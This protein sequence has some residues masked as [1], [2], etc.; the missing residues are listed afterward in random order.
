MHATVVPGIHKELMSADDYFR[1][2]KFNILLRQPDYEDGVSELYRPAA[3]GIPE[4]RIPLVYDYAGKVDGIC[5]S[6]LPK[7]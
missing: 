7:Q 5:T 3:P 6:S 1:H 4:A 2:G